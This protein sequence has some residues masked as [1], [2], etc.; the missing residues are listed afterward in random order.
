MLTDGQE[1]ALRDLEL[2]ARS[3]DALEILGETEP[4]KDNGLLLVVITLSFRGVRRTPDGIPL[5]QRERFWVIVPPAYPYLHPHVAVPHHRWAGW[6]HVQWKNWPCLYQAPDTEWNPGDG[7]FGFIDRLYKWVKQ[8]AINQLDP[9]GAPLHPPVAYVSDTSGPLVIPY[10]D[11]PKVEDRPW[12]GFGRVSERTDDRLDVIGW[13]ELEEI[14]P[15]G[16]VS[17]AILLPQPASYEFPDK[18]TDLLELL[19]GQ[20]ISRTDLVRV[21]GIAASINGKDTQLL[22]L[23]GTPTRGIQGSE[24]LRQNLVAWLLEPAVANGLRLAINQFSPDERLQ[25]IGLECERIV[26]NWAESAK[27]NWCRLREARPEVTVRRDEDSPLAWFRDKSVAVLGC[28]AIGGHVAEAL[29]R[30]G[31][32]KLILWDK[33]PVTPGVLVRQP[34]DDLD[35]GKNKAVATEGA[36]PKDNS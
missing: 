35:I 7:M 29:A 10:A 30:A 17:A 2:N 6:P 16:P 18:V 36:A 15:A 13:H 32:A 23:I 12:I 25:E 26:L 28:G 9:V 19:Q 1:S 33:S 11:T 3:G 34:F 5:R 14:S 27:V 21:L 4:E 24:E 20:G 31:V 22:V 8:A